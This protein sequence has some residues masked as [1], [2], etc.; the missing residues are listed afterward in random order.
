[1]S[2]EALGFVEAIGLT[3][4]VEAADAAVKSANVRLIGYELARG[5]G[6]TTIKVEGDVG[7]V[8]AAVSAAAAAAGRV[9]TVVST[10]VIPRPAPGTER[11]V[12]SKDTV[13]LK[14]EKPKAPPRAPETP[15]ADSVKPPPPPPPK[16]EAPKPPEPPRASAPEAPKAPPSQKSKSQQP[17]KPQKPEGGPELGING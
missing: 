1:M 10:H 5:D 7:A 8:K 15:P 11:M 12:M 3:A 17:K 2:G 4:A 14:A 13:G 16:A 9:G 6:M